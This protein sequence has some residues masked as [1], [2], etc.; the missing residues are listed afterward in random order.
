[1]KP[2]SRSPLMYFGLAA[3][4]LLT[5]AISFYIGLQ[6][7]NVHLDSIRVNQEWADRRERY[8]VLGAMAVQVKA[9]GNDAFDDHDVHREE[10]EFDADLLQY[11]RLMQGA[12]SELTP[13]LVRS[14]RL[15]DDMQLIDAAMARMVGQAKRIFRNSEAHQTSSARQDKALLENDY[16][17]LN[18]TLVKLQT[19]IAQLQKA[20]FASQAKA[21]ISL[22]RY[23][24]LVALGVG[25][26]VLVMTFYGYRLSRSLSAT[27]EESEKAVRALVSSEKQHRILIEAIPHM[28][29]TNTPDGTVD[30]CNQK[31]LDYTGQTMSDV[32]DNGWAKVVHPDDVQNAIEKAMLAVSALQ[33]SEMEYRIRRA[34]DGV[35]RWHLATSVPLFDE[36]GALIKW[37]GSATDIESQ[38]READ[39]IRESRNSLE[40][41]VVERT[42]ELVT[43]NRALRRSE[44]ASLRAREKAEAASVAKGEFL[45]NMSHEIRTP[46]NGVIGMVELS[47]DTELSR[48]QREYLDA[49]KLS[50]DSLLSVISDIL[51]FSKIEAGRLDL[52]PVSF[53]LRESLGDAMGT[54]AFRAHTK[55]LE[56]A[57]QVSPN[58]PESLIGDVGRLRQILVNLVGNAIKFTSTGEVVVAVES[59]SSSD[60]EVTLRL[61]VRDT[62][63]GIAPEKQRIVFDAFSQADS[64]TTREYGGT[65]LGLAITSKLVAAMGGTIEVDSEP[66][67]GSTFYCTL[68]LVVDPAGG[69]ALP[70]SR[71]TNLRGLTV[72]VV[73][74]NVTNCRILEQV[75][76][77][78]GMRSTIV[79]DGKA[80]IAAMQLALDDGVPFPLVLL[81][82]QMPGMDGFGVVEEIRSQPGL[83]GS[84]IMMLSSCDRHNPVRCRELGIKIYLTKPIRQAQLFEAIQITLGSAARVA[85]PANREGTTLRPPPTR[86]SLK[87]LVVEDNAVNRKLAVALLKRRN[88]EIVVAN[89]GREGVEA[90]A[91]GVFDVVLMDVQMPEM[92]GFEATAIIRQMELAS[93][94]HSP[95]IAMTARAMKGDRERCLEAGMDDYVAKPINPE[96]LY[97]AIDRVLNL[98]APESPAQLDKPIRVGFDRAALL[99]VAGGDT[100]L[101]DELAELFLSEGPEHLARISTAIDAGDARALEF[102][103]HALKGSAASLTARNVAGVAGRLEAMGVALDLTGAEAAFAELSDEMMALGATLD[104]SVRLIEAA[105]S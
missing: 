2:R 39:V 34:A 38:K 101:A 72:L 48:E 19:D 3:V 45:A 36:F 55:G 47:L 56:L 64:S 85:P 86:R 90:H 96:A 29:W 23:Q 80:A 61:S 69:A 66:G 14:T 1:M 44:R 28:V 75:L 81:D 26:M 11:H 18:S 100:E 94:R 4:D 51:D 20:R 76:S 52:D 92:G 93:G 58:V 71:A 65:G 5:F 13:E 37:F 7:L 25:L 91:R 12:V 88:H 82:A 43:T 21:G 95:I 62:G 24:Y 57:L 99:R 31:W 46:L 10:A 50:A 54:L 87:I 73:D 32:Q 9:S 68:R 40:R 79:N 102:A 60:G 105:A 22:H 89:N 98:V 27:A 53:Q 6:L 74:D 77:S 49:A 16:E 8:A 33:P 103:A 15:R 83:A 30:Y 42:E 70:G 67:K 63:I 35:Y 17:R 59:E 84:A 78:W 97:A 104:P 41:A